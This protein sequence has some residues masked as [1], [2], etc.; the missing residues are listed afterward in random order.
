MPNISVIMPCL[1]VQEYIEKCLQSVLN[2]TMKDLE[3]IVIDAGSTDGT[4]DILEVYCQRDSRIR[5]LHSDRKSYGYQ[6][7]LGIAAA[8]GDYIA[9]VET[10]DYVA[11]DMME[12]LYKNIY[13]TNAAYIKGTGEGFFEKDGRYSKL[14]D[15]VPCREL[16]Q[17]A[18]VVCDPRQYAY[19][20]ISDN[21]LWNGLYRRDYLQGIHF[22]E[23]PGAAFQDIGVLFQILCKAPKGIYLNKLV[24]HYRQ[25]NGGA[26]SYNS[27]GLNFVCIEYKALL[28]RLQ[29]ILPAWRK[30]YYQKMAGH[31]IDRFYFMIYGEFWAE[32]T[33]SIVWLQEHL[34][35]A[36]A[37]KILQEADFSAQEW[38]ELQLFLQDPHQLFAVLKRKL[39]QYTAEARGYLQKFCGKNIF[40]FGCGQLG[41]QLQIFLSACG[42]DIRG[43]CDNSLAKQETIVNDFKVY[44]LDQALMTCPQAYFI[45]ANKL[46]WE[47]IKGQLLHHGVDA[48]NIFTAYDKIHMDLFVLRNLLSKNK[49]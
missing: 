4:L 29:G 3:I 8:V 31:T 37:K 12:V 14:F 25:D 5:L 13:L 27:K 43:F 41:Q 26:S 24:Y 42:V 7:N 23:T 40:V 48:E 45:V 38:S 18:C 1:N 33:E 44:L 10:D 20:F 30:I 28:P 49:G 46:H 36:L 15:V 34:R 19:L 6:M 17:K 35:E 32:S 47:D 9:I 21:F 39:M 22:N 2:Q 11:L 16:R